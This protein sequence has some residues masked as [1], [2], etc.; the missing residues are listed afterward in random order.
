M[1]KQIQVKNTKGGSYVFE[2]LDVDVFVLGEFLV[3][4]VC[5]GRP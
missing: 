1:P 3:F 2:V 5:F 4:R